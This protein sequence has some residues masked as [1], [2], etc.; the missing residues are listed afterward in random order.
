MNTPWQTKQNKA[1]ADPLSYIRRPAST[2][3]T[4]YTTQKKQ[5]SS[6]P[7]SIA[8]PKSYS[9][10][11]KDQIFD[12]QNEYKSSNLFTQSVIDSNKDW[13]NQHPHA[14]DKAIEEQNESDKRSELA[15]NAVDYG[16]NILS[17]FNPIA[18]VS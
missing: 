3:F 2:A 18:G 15:E 12:R 13:V 10:E 5:S 9:D 14:F 16:L 11:V 4:G 7:Q 17:A 1:K 6:I 8:K